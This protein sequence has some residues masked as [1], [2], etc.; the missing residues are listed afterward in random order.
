VQVDHAWGMTETSP[1][2]T[3]NAEQWQTAD[4]T[5]EARLRHRE[6]QGRGIFG[7]DMKIVDGE[8]L[9]LP[10]NGVAQGDL[11]V[12]GIWVAGA[13]W[14]DLPGSACDADGWFATGDVA[15]IDEFGTMEITDRSKDVIKSGGEW[16]SSI[17][18]ENIAVSHPDVAEAAIIAASHPKWTE[19]PVL[20]VVARAGVTIDPASVLAIY[21]GKIPSW[22]L[23]DAVVVVDELPHTATGKVHKLTLRARYRDHLNN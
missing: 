22:W 11:K 14:G 15:T 8:G 1:L 3:Y 2:G 16:I 10:W 13:Y 12:R 17:A 20:V 9:E 4:F 21:D 19:R 6:K 7:I 5:G 23:P 18:L